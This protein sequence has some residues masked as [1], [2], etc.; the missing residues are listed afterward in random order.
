MLADITRLQPQAVYVYVIAIASVHLHHTYI[1]PADIYVPLGRCCHCEE[2][3]DE[4]ISVVMCAHNL[5]GIASSLR[6]SQ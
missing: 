2:H 6:S 3:S 4:A 1:V 5:T